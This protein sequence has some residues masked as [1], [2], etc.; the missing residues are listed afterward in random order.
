LDHSGYLPLLIRKGF[1]GRVF[2][3][4]ATRDLR[5]ILLPDSGYLQEKDAEYANRHGF[6]KHHPALPLYTAEEARASLERFTV[7]AFD[8]PFEPVPGLTVTFR[9]AGHILGAAL[10]ELRVGDRRLVFSGDLGRPHDPIM[11]E[12]AV[13]RLADF[14]VVESTYGN[15][16]HEPENPEDVL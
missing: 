3:T 16:L 12:P 5:A 13:V 9:P 11:I 10:A 4:P 7:H 1:R 8:R 15:R 6:S 2:S 14:L